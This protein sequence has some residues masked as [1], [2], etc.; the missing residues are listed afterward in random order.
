[1]KLHFL[2]HATFV[3]TLG[4]LTLLVDPMFSAA[5]AMPP[6]PHAGNEYRIPMVDLPLTRAEL[7]TLLPDVDAVLLSHTHF[8]H[9][10]DEAKTLLPKQLP[11]LCQP[12]DQVVLEQAGFTSVLPIQQQTEWQGLHISRTGG[13]HG[14]GE[15]GKMMGPVSGFV[16]K[17]KDEPSLYIAGD[18]I[19][20]EE[21]EQA[22]E[23]YTPEV[24]VLYAGSAQYVTG[25]GPITMT[26]DDVCQVA[27]K[28]PAAQI[29]AIHMEVINHCVL[30]RAEL[31]TR[32]TTEGLSQRVQVPQDGEVLIF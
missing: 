7:L 2:R 16:L 19:W 29:V 22:L 8:D 17:G 3:V 26:A 15:L 25:G 30:T 20:C 14:S 18:T 32:L 13:R 12:E 27:H 23:Q 4:D 6:I 11:I 21:V 10:D 31:K 5:E 24:V 28:V 9:W 1:M